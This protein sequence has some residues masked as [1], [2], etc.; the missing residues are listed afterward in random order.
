MKGSWPLPENKATF[1]GYNRVAPGSHRG[2]QAQSS[3]PA[4][5]RGTSRRQPET[6]PVGQ[7]WPQQVGEKFGDKK[8]L[9]R[10][11][12]RAQDWLPALCRAGHHPRGLAP[13]LTFRELREGL[14]HQDV[15]SKTQAGRTPTAFDPER[16]QM[17][18]P[19]EVLWRLG[20][21]GL[22]P[23][24]RFPKPGPAE[25]RALAVGVRGG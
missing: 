7:A 16:Q 6:L 19:I 9:P 4:P 10:A 20:C 1:Q 21:Q 12:G 3:R 23:T 14:S 13:T 11:G 8:R 22:L 25:S 24:T 18:W 2:R 15:V 5:T 17:P